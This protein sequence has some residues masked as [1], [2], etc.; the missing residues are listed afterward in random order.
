MH[1]RVTRVGAIGS[2]VLALAAGVGLALWPCMYRGAAGSADGGP[3]RQF[4]AS[5][6]EVNGVWALAVLAFPVL[7]AGIGVVAV[8]VGRRG[9]LMA[10]TVGLVA[11][12]VVAL[13]SV[14]LFY[15]PALA[16]LVVALAGW[17]QPAGE[18]G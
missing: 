16:A 5:L 14:G 8:R 13:S 7:L 6:V 15:L 18:G 10:A 4:C 2:L 3:E 9:V 11:F 17:R 1:S 12:C